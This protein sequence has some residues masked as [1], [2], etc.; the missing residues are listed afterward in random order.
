MGGYSEQ[1]PKLLKTMRWNI[2]ENPFYLKVAN[3]FNFLRKISF[4]RKSLLRSVLFDFLAYTGSG[5]LAISALQ[6]L[7][8]CKVSSGHLSVK[9]VDKFDE[10]SE[11]LWDKVKNNYKLIAVRNRDTLNILYSNSVRFKHIEIFEN[12][13]YIGWAI[14]LDTQMDNHKQFGSMRVGS[15]VDCL[16][17]PDNACKILSIATNYLLNCKVDIIVANHSHYRW[18]AAF[19]R[20]GFIQGPSNFLFAASRELSKLIN[21]LEKNKAQLYFMRGDGDGPINL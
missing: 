17:H 8:N 6:S 14:L 15:I 4:L 1:L 9:Q 18:G 7:K 21:P 5:W 16:A 20:L 3:P 12:Q 2:C 11:F 13:Q 10:K 19:N